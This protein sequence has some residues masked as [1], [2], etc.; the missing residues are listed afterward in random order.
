MAHLVG[1]ISSGARGL[2]ELDGEGFL[3]SR[4]E[5]PWVWDGAGRRYVDT[6]LGFGATVLGHAPPAVCAAVREAIDRGPM[7]A[8]PHALE[9]AAAAALTAQTGPLDRAVFTNTGSEAVHLA[10]RVARAATGRGTIAKF[11]AGYDGWYDEVAFGNAGSPEALM[12]ANARPQRQRTVLLRFNDLDDAR[13]LFEENGDIAALVIEPVLA[14]AGCIPPAPGYLA[15]LA[16]LARSS[17]AMVIADEVLMGFRLQ[18]GLTSPLL[19]VTPDLATVGKAIGSGFA[20]AA[21][22]GTEAAMAPLTEGRVPRAGTYSG[23]PVACAAVCAT[24]ALLRGMD[25]AALLRDGDRLRQGIEAEFAAAGLPVCTSGYGNVFTLWRGS[26]PPGTYADALARIDHGFNRL[27]HDALRREG[28]VSMAVPFGRHYLSA[29]HPGEA[30]DRLDE[31]FRVCAR[32]IGDV[33]QMLN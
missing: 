1:G 8:F 29:T 3:V 2:P 30:L 5:G 28:V 15:A 19:G 7:P 9:E 17:G 14:N 6:A 4:S 10:C 23:N 32:R 20:V 13:R 22:L 31:A 18:A 21:V 24:M 11:A 12:Q 26:E 16:A 27:M 25:Y 33:P